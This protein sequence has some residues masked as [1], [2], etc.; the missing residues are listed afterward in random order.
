MTRGM[1][2]IADPS[3]LF[4]EGLRRLLRQERL[5]VCAEGRDVAEALAKLDD[6][7]ECTLV[8]CTLDA[9]TCQPNVA[10]LKE[11]RARFPLSKI[12]VI[13]DTT[14]SPS[15]WREAV[16]ITDALLARDISGKVLQRAIDL[17]ML[18]QKFFSL[19]PLEMLSP[20]E[21]GPL[22]T[23]RPL[24]AERWHVTGPI[25]GKIQQDDTYTQPPA[26]AA[27]VPS[28]AEGD[29]ALSDR[30]RQILSCLIHGQ[31]NKVIA[32]ELDIAEATVKVHVKGLLRKLRAANRTQAAVWALKHR[33]ALNG[34]E[35][36]AAD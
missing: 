14:L 31:S 13:T 7:V 3:P 10:R 26:P 6:T 9:E 23:G 27:E 16:N 29:F 17:V 1:A 34:T 20:E 15:L 32:R 35:V 2:L 36:L 18:G 21:T 11:V 22:S 8:I 30:E 19:P 25:L 24:L 5:P 4:C 12:I 28:L 33:S